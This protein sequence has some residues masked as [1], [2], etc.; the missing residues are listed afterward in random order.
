MV[1]FF[2]DLATAAQR[3]KTVCSPNPVFQRAAYVVLRALALALLLTLQVTRVHAHQTS[4]PL[5]FWADNFSFRETLCQHKLAAGAAECGFKAWSIRRDCLLSRLDGGSC[6]E[7]ASDE[8]IEQVRLSVFQGDISPSCASADLEVLLFADQQDVQLDVVTFCREF[9][10]AALSLVFNP[11]LQAA[12]TDTLEDGE[13]QCIKAFARAAT[14]DFSF[15]IRDRQNT[16]D[17]IANRRRSARIK[18]RNVSASDQRVADV[19]ELLRKGLIKDCSES[20]FQALYGFGTEQALDLATSRSACFADQV[21][22][23]LAYTC[24]AP[25]CGN[26][27]REKGERCDDGNSDGGDGCSE[28]CQLEF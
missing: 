25:L 5:T 20:D 16:L 26:G 27:M 22:P 2:E 17:R 12:T 13:R 19:S 23:V 4:V 18:N 1:C 8:A 9:E 6:D 21:Y 14:K 15:T 11:Y 28:R 10:A 3:R 7:E 24:P